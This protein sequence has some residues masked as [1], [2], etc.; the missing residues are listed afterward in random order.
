MEQWEI[1]QTRAIYAKCDLDELCQMRDK[2]SRHRS[3]AAKEMSELLQQIL[4]ERLAEEETVSPAAWSKATTEPKK[5]PLSPAEEKRREG[6]RIERETQGGRFLPRPKD[7]ES[8]YKSQLDYVQQQSLMRAHLPFKGVHSCPDC[9]EGRRAP[10]CT[11]HC[12]QPGWWQAKRA[13][14]AETA[15][16]EARRSEKE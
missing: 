3:S 6:Q 14:L 4:K 15:A 7:P 16:Y 2:Y 5:K 13:T 11:S 8:P 9:V 12:D 10:S 1:D